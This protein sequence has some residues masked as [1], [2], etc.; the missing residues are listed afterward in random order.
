MRLRPRDFLKLGQLFLDGGIRK[1]RRVVSE[2][3][4][5]QATAPQTKLNN[6]N[7]DG[8]NWW[9]KD[10]RAGDRTVH[11]YSAGGNGGQFVVVAP[12]L[13]LVVAFTGGT[14]GNFLL[15]QRFAE[16]LLTTYV[17]PAA[18]GAPGER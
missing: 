4:V 6:G 18:R 3:W 10:L 2:K 5:A 14:Y 17:F 13:D 11:T 8:Y 16:E 12:Q 7:T 15:A 1:G 9:I